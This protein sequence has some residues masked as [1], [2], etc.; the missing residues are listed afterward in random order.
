[1]LIETGDSVQRIEG[2]LSGTLGFIMTGL[3]AGA[4]FSECVQEA[5]RLGYTEPDPVV[6]LSGGD[7]GRK[8]L[9]LARLA[10]LVAG[11]E[12]PAISGL[13]TN[14]LADSAPDALWKRLR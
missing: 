9:I 2:C 6:D 12:Q 7:V 4:K 14:D 11:N 3:E 10:G 5:A 8:A 1:M 13:V